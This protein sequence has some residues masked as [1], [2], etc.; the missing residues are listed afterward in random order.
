[1][2]INETLKK[3]RNSKKLS[4]SDMADILEV[5]LSSYQ[6]YERDKNCITPSLDVLMRIADFYNV[7]I[8]YL[9]GRET[10]EPETIDKLAGEFNMSALEKEILDN[11]LSLPK[12]MR[13]DLMEFLQKSVQKVMNESGE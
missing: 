4:Q 8:D 9:L 12:D 6:K 13:G 7:S 10:G 5:S 1:M 11:Y 3:L 2:K